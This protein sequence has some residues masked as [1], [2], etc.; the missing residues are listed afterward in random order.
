M[1]DRLAFAEADIIKVRGSSD[2]W[3]CCF[4]S[5]DGQSCRI[6]ADRPEECRRM[7]C[8]DTRE[9]ET[10]YR[11]ERLSRRDLLGGV[12]GLWEVIAHHEERCSYHRLQALAPRLAA[13]AE[14]REQAM[15]AI[16]DMVRY[17]ESLRQLLVEQGQAR[18]EMLDFLLGRPLTETLAGFHVRV[19]REDD[20]IQLT[21]SPLT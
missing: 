10:L 16:R 1:A 9:I 2:G 14:E 19:A 12:E 3:T 11:R 13:A 6:Y 20:R 7:Q 15:T 5:E 8:W 18:Q 17:D 21:Y 4:L